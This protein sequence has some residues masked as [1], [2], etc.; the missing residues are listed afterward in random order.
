L[1]EQAVMLA[2]WDTPTVAEADKLT[3][4]SH[5]GIRR[6]LLGPTSESSDVQITPRAVLAPEFS[7]WLM[8]YPS[9]W[10]EAAPGSS[11]WQSVQQELTASAA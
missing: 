11:E 4:R 7:R 10:D 8:G 3:T 2:G 5:T 1:N 9:A 6:Q